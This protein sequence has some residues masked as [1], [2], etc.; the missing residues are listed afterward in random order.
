[1]LNRDF[2]QELF[3]RYKETGRIDK[4]RNDISEL[5]I[6][7]KHKS[8]LKWHYVDGL[9]FKTIGYLIAESENLA[10]PLSERQVN[11]RH[12]K[13]LELAFND[14]LQRFIKS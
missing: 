14:I 5:E 2:L 12:S 13:A 1:M 6:E 3:S 7:E 8:L 10:Q 4:L 9:P 11:R